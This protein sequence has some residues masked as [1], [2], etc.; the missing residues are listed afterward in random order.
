MKG[1]PCHFF[2]SPSSVQVLR[3]DLRRVGREPVRAEGRVRLAARAVGLR[4]DH[5][6]CGWSPAS[7]AGCG[8][9]ELDGQDITQAPATTRD[10]GFVFQTYALFPHMTVARQRRASASRCAAAG[11]PER[12]ARREAL[13]AGAARGA[14]REVAARAAPAASTSASPSPA[15]WSIEPRGAAARRAALGPRRQAAR[16]DAGRAA[17]AA[18]QGRHHHALRD[19]RPG[20]AL[21][22]ATAWW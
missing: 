22:M 2:N 6:R 20:E 10:L 1:R 18:A 7:S 21:S 4:Q 5:A 13:D 3:H 14:S 16:R 8:R 19:A 11:R 9:V 12:Q 17:P 15:R